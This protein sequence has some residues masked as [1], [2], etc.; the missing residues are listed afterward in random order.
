MTGSIAAEMLQAQH[1]DWAAEWWS[2]WVSPGARAPEQSVCVK[3]GAP[4]AV[5]S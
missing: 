2:D 3:L 5:A 4:N 1:E